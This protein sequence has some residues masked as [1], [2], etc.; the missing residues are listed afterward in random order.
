MA[1]SLLFDYVA[2]YMYEDDTP[3]AER[4]AQALSL[5]REL[6]RELLGQEELRDLLDPGALAEVEGSLLRP[7]RNA[8]ELHDLLRRAGDLRDRELDAGFAETLVRERR[9]FRARIGDEDATIAAEDAGLYRDAFGVMPPG[10]LPES[11]LEAV[12]DAL[13]RVLLRYARSRGPF[14]TREVAARYALVLDR[15]EE[16]LVDARGP[17]PPRPGRAPPRRRRARVVRPRGPASHPARLARRPPAPG[18]AGRAG[19]ARSFPAR[20]GTASTAGPRCAR[21]SSRSRGSRFPSRCGRRRSSRDA[22]RATSRRR[23]T[24]SAPRARSSGSAR[25]STGWRSTTARTRRCS[26]LRRPASRSAAPFRCRDPGGARARRGVLADLVA[27]LG[28]DAPDALPV[29]LGARL[30]R[31]G[32]QRRLGPAPRR[33][34]ATASLPRSAARGA[35]PAREL[36]A[37]WRPPAAGR[38]PGGSSG[39]ATPCRASPRIAAPSPSCCSSGRGSS[40]ATACVPRGSRAAT[41][42]STASLRARD[43]GRLPPRLLRRG[44]RRRAVRAAG[45]RRAASRAAR[46]RRRRGLPDAR[47]GRRRPGPALR[48]RA[49]V[50]TARRRARG[51]RRRGARRAARRGGGAVRRPRW[52]LAPSASRSRPRLAPPGARRAR[53]LGEGRAR[54]GAFRSSASTACR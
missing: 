52:P 10:G 44:A 8:D 47:A 45:R 25:A 30:E 15:V 49:P 33:N 20:R 3:A 7:P 21:R 4:R 36:R 54:R 16:L 43:G 50:A 5:D 32:H 40:P 39:R 27:A 26:G 9:A 11:F 46:L 22:C 51:A 14:T 28:V 34:A 17:R 18:R 38:S 12:D 6:L 31:R 19:R 37:T 13:E 48:R 35:S 42:R 53:R 23:S 24:S 41:A 1:S 2:T 29:T